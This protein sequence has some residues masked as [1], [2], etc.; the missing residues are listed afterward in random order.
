MMLRKNII[1]VAFCIFLSTAVIAQQ[2]DLSSLTVSAK[3]T[4]LRIAEK[5]IRSPHGVYNAPGTKAHIPYFEVCVWHGALGFAGLTK[6]KTLYQQLNNRFSPLLDTDTALLPVPDHVDYT[7]FGAI[8]LEMYLQK[9]GEKYYRLGMAYADTQWAVPFGPRVTKESH[10][11][12]GNGYSWQTRLWIDDMYM[13]T[14]I[15]AQ[16]YRATKNRKYIERTAREMSLYLDKLQQANGLFHHAPG[17]PFF[18]GRG[19]GWMAAGMTELLRVLPGNNVYYNRIFKAYTT[20]METLLRY[21]SADGMWRQLVDDSTSW[22]ETSSTGMFAYAMITGVKNGWLNR[23]DYEPA[24]YKAWNTLITYINA[25]AEITNVCE[26]TGTRNDRQYYLDR[27][28]ITG[29]FHG[30]APVL[31]CVN[32]LLRRKGE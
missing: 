25:D 24:A 2:Y 6:N 12:F 4:G 17:I 14:M 32:A 23:K 30:Q 20:M 19:N 1:G 27:K 7:V 16:A 22:K 10:E 31:W 26:G 9:G 28:K 29:D 21:Q 11:Y 3:T 8:P 13:I 5:F 18:W 15:Q